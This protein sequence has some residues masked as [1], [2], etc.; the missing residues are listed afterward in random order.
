ML[1]ILFKVKSNGKSHLY[2]LTKNSF[3]ANY[4]DI[5]YEGKV[6]FYINASK[7]QSIKTY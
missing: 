3:S 7:H 6:K 4:R 2:R 5:V 1:K